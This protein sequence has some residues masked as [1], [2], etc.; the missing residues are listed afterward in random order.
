[1]LDTLWCDNG[2]EPR[3]GI[4]PW[5]WARRSTWRTID[6]SP[7]AWSIVI[8]ESIS[9]EYIPHC[10][11]QLDLSV[12]LKGIE[13][14][15]RSRLNEYYPE[16]KLTLRLYKNGLQRAPLTWAGGNC[17]GWQFYRRLDKAMYRCVVPTLNPWRKCRASI[18][19]MDISWWRG[20]VWAFR[21]TSFQ[22]ERVAYAIWSN[23]NGLKWVQLGVKWEMQLQVSGDIFCLKKQCFY[24]I[25]AVF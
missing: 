17:V 15:G 2:L 24:S 1:M 11:I 18:A 5:S 10:S 9:L 20:T 25:K 13:Y 21:N 4:E 6:K 3:Y 22:Q 23:W 12:L 8:G 14:R 16:D 19:K 7:K